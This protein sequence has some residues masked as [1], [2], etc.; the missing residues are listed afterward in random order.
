VPLPV[1]A[2]GNPQMVA[3]SEPLPPPHL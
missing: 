1:L 2:R 3:T